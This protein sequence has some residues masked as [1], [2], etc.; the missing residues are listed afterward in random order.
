MSEVNP[1]ETWK[2]ID[3]FPGY[4]VSDLGRVR[5]FLNPGHHNIKLKEDPSILGQNALPSGYWYVSPRR[6]GKNFRRYVHRLVLTAFVGP[7]PEGMET[8]HINSNDRSDNR[9]AN[10]CWG[11]R[12]E[13]AADRTRHGTVMRGNKNHRS[14][15]TASK[16]IL[17]RLLHASG[18]PICNLKRLFDQRPENILKI[19][20]RETWAH[21]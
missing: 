17:I 13:N 15:L 18:T 20:K 16:V 3:E 6:D 4:Q 2:D 5:T 8:R 19:V 21:V 7:C 11:T 12:L 10:L 1:I 14:R 9:L